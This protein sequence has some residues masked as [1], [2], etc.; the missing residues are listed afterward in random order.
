MKNRKKNLYL[1]IW[2]CLFC[3]LPLN[4][5]TQCVSFAKNVA[6]TKLGEF[7]HDGNYNATI[8]GAGE[9]A[10]LYKTFFEGETYR[11]T[12]S[13]IESLPN[14][15]FRLMDKDNHIL[16]DNLKHNFADVWDFKVQSTQMLVL[17]L[18]VLDNF[19]N[20]QSI[21]KGCVAVLFGVKK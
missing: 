10:E 19:E 6:K 13:K 5:W 9:T 16:F 11:V 21:T 14:I 18:K 17:K 12:I 15:H 7:V 1:V 8:L 20:E 3:L 4:G 2:I